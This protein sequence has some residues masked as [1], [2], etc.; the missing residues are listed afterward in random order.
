MVRVYPVLLAVTL[1][2]PAFAA[3]SQVPLDGQAVN[4]LINGATISIDTPIGTT[5]PVRYTAD[6][7][8]SGEAGSVAFALGA[9][10]DRGKWWVERDRLCHRWNVWFEREQQCMRLRLS[11]DRLFWVRDD[12][13]TGTAT[14]TVRPQRPAEATVQPFQSA[15]MAPP[16]PQFLSQPLRALPQVEDPTPPKVT[17]PLPAVAV[18]PAPPVVSQ[19][20]PAQPAKQPAPAAKAAPAKK[21]ARAADPASLPKHLVPTQAIPPQPA[22]Q[23]YKVA[24][25][26]DDDVL[27]VRS[28]PS[29]DHPPVG[30]IPPAAQGVKIMGGCQA[31]W[32]LVAHRNVTGWVNRYYLVAESPS[33]V[34]SPAST[35]VQQAAAASRR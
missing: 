22:I 11:G 27:N 19:P 30:E 16:V 17:K 14:L 3:S 15:M 20:S 7:Q 24:F 13:K 31:D 10:T 5:V 12:G 6:G 26:D 32:C 2:S 29:S 18:K 28:G 9:P 8:M 23:T 35:Q 34:A 21:T 33:S 25:V 1:S 4:N